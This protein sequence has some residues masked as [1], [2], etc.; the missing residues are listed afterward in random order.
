MP[1]AGLAVEFGERIFQGFVNEA[2]EKRAAGNRPEREALG[3][4]QGA[5][6]HGF[7]EIVPGRYAAPRLAE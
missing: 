1:A 3:V 5:G 7:V 4:E 2:V 6:Q